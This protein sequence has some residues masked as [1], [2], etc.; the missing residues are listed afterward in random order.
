MAELEL[1]EIVSRLVVFKTRKKRKSGIV[2]ISQVLVGQ[3]TE[4]KSTEIKSEF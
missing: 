1:G 3:E 4:K 2:M